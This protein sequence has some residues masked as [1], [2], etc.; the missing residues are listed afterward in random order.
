M[1]TVDYAEC[2]MFNIMTLRIKI[3]SVMTLN[4][5]DSFKCVYAERSSINVML[6]VNYAQCHYTKYNYLS[7]IILSVIYSW[8]N[9]TQNNDIKCNKIQHDQ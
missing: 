8:Y 2:Q 4:T 1:L 7:V 9:S 5:N 3:F 6:I